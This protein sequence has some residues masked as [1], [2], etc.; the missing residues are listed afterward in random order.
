MHNLVNIIIKLIKILVYVDTNLNDVVYNGRINEKYN[1]IKTMTGVH[2]IEHQD[3][4]C[5]IF[6][7]VLFFNRKYL[8]SEHITILS[9]GYLK[10]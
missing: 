3:L 1:L 9:D 8:I 7:L 2:I 10:I 6:A 4:L 5:D